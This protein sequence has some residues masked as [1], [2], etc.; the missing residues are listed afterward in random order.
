LAEAARATSRLS[1]GPVVTNPYLRHPFHT[2]SA[3]ATLAE[4]A[5]DDRVFVGLAAGGS[6]VTGAAGVPR[7]DAPRRVADLIGLLR[8]VAGG[9]PLDERSGRPLDVT[10]PD[11]PVLVAARGDGLLR[12]AGASADHLLL[13]AVPD[14]DLE[15]SVT[16]A[17]SG[18]T[19]AQLVWA[20]L[21]DWGPDVAD[22]LD[23]LACYALMNAG[24][25][26]RSRWG[27][28]EALVEAVR[29]DLVAGR[30]AEA[31]RRLPEAVAEDLIYRDPDPA[32][33]AARGREL[34]FT[35]I[36]VPAFSVDTVPERV[37]W[38]MAVQRELQPAG[39]G[40]HAAATVR[41]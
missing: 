20:P 2:A 37:A 35:G 22:Q 33:L 31:R 9:A 7:R 14:S 4:L 25:Q 19:R 18:G 15:R 6:E 30:T 26:L 10:L 17:R 13:W 24:Q 34:G 36:A 12:V 27:A 1:L 16:V 38:A 32:R 40:R 28:D 8:S 39:G 3:L 5:G 23:G 11:V 29:A 21:V 41:P